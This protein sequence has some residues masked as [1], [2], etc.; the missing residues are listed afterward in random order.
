MTAKFLE[1]LF[2]SSIFSML[3]FDFFVLQSYKIFVIV[4]KVTKN[5]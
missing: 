2:F 1:A 4:C 5:K 3:F